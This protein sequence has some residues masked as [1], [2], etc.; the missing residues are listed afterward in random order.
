MLEK[1]QKAKKVILLEPSNI[2]GY[3]PLG[4]ARIATYVKQYGG[5]VVYQ[6]KYKP[7]GEDLV[8]ITTLFTWYAHKIHQAIDEV[9]KLSIIS[10]NVDIIVGGVYVALLPQHAEKE[11]PQ[12]HYFIGCSKVL[13]FCVPDYTLD[14]GLEDKWN[15]ISY[16]YTSRGC[17]NK[18]EY[19]SAWKIE[20][21]QY[22]IDTWKE[23]IDLARPIVMIN[24]NNLSSQ[25]IEYIREIFDYIKSNNLKLNIKNGMDCKYIT[26]ELAT[27]LGSMKFAPRGMKLAFDRISEDGVFQEAVR[28]LIAAGVPRNKFMI[29]VL[30]NFTETPLEAIYR[31]TE[32][33][34]LKIDPWPQCF[35]K[36]NKLS[37]KE[38]YLGKHWTP[39]LRDAF[40]M[41]YLFGGYYRKNTFLSWCLNE[42]KN[43]NKYH[44]TPEELKSIGG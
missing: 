3:F 6:K 30:Y 25:P 39:N 10:G 44:F 4:L 14:Y 36:M 35:V 43:N 13:D 1:L 26:D 27:L 37:I 8:C 7:V 33:I 12:A 41:F 17:A 24:D 21:E 18:C 34:K 42:G 19:C 5:E 38:K 20:P 32:V 16:I 31:M 29:Y 2:R 15:Q 9:L 22:R 40:H 28:K 23:Q 11:H